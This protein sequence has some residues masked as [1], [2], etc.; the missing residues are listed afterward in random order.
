MET[1]AKKVQNEK[2]KRIKIAIKVEE[3]TKKNIKNMA[4]KKQSLKYKIVLTSISKLSKK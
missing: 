3:K 2:I 1:L 4:E